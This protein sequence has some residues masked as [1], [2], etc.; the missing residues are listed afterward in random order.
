MERFRLDGRRALVT[1]GSKGIGLGIAKGLAEAGA[2]LVLLARNA[3]AL[4]RARAEV[5]AYGRAVATHVADLRHVRAIKSVYG[6]IVAAHG[7]IDIL[8]NNAGGTH[9]AP[10]EDL[11]LEDWNAVLT[12]NL[13]AAFALCRAFARDAIARRGP[14]GPGRRHKIVNIASLLSEAARANNAPYAA[15][16]GGIRQ[17]TKALAVEWAGR[18]I[19]VNAI[20]PGYIRTPLT[21][22][23][24]E[25]AGFDAWVKERTPLARWGTPDDLAGAAVFLASDASDF[26]TGQ[27]LYVDGGWLASL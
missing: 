12:L 3:D 5:A 10:A 4:E 25:D 22:P 21:Q 1:G 24:Y 23:L 2:D 27:V 7:P 16:K 6:G 11:D 26:V 9:R 20:G 13:T 17:L 15:S 14:A 19:N 8:V 18:G